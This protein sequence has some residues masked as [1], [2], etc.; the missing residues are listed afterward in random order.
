MA[1][2]ALDALLAVSRTID[3]INE[4]FGVV[5]NYLVLFACLVSAANAAIRYGLDAILYISRN[6]P[7]MEGL[8]LGL[9][10]YG[11]NANAFL[12]LQWYMFTGIVLLGAPFTLK[13]NEHVRVDVLYGMAPQRVRIFI[14]IFGTIFFL[15]PICLILAYYT[16]F[17]FLDSWRINET[18][19]NAGGL[20]RWPVKLILPVGFALMVLQGVS[21]LIKRFAALAG[22]DTLHYRYESPVQ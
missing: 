18:S 22:R 19:S 6:V 7:Y 20:I 5:A 4:R 12:E 10:W 13:V 16:W 21:E 14:D 3:W 17:W 8:Q 1:E 9:A 11:N 2:G 15:M